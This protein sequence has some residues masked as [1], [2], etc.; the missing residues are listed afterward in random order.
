MIGM[1][2]SDT[3]TGG[4]AGLFIV[5]ASAGTYRLAAIDSSG[6]VSIFCFTTIL[7]V[8]TLQFIL[9]PCLCCYLSYGP[10]DMMQFI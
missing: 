5:C 9:N 7:D 2:A 3:A 10:L 1:A 8:A 6:L 4:F